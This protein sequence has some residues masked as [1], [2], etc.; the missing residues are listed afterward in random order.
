[1]CWKWEEMKD[2]SSFLLEPGAEQRGIS[3]RERERERVSE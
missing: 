3:Q 1:M 2:E